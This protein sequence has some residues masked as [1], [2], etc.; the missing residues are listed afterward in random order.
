MIMIMSDNLRQI[1]FHL[2][3]YPYLGLCA[4]VECRDMRYDVGRGSSQKTILYNINVTVPE[5]SM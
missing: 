1:S 2:L 4:A 3:Y 5:G